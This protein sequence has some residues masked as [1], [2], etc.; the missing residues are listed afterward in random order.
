MKGQKWQKPEEIK[1]LR[2]LG[3]TVKR[4]PLPLFWTGSG[5]ECN[6]DGTELWCEFESD[7]E[8]YEQWI[9]VFVNGALMSRLMLNKGRQQVC[10]Y[11]NMGTRKVNHIKVVKEVQAMPGDPAAYLAICG[12][13]GDGA[14]YPLPEP[15]CRIEFIGDSITSGEGSYGSTVE[16]DW[17]AMWFSAS[18]TFPWFVAERLNAEYRVFSQ[19][20]YGVYCAYD[21]N[22][23]HAMP[24]YYEQVCGVL[25]GERN[26]ALG[27]KERYEFSYWQPDYIVINLGTND[28][29]AFHN[30]EWQDEATGRRNKMEVGPD[31]LPEKE[32]LEKVRHAVTEFLCMVRKYNPEAQILWAYGLMG[33]VVE[34]AITEGIE[35]FRKTSGDTKVH[36]I[37]LD[38]IKGEAVGARS[39]PGELG[40]RAAAESICRVIEGLKSNE[41]E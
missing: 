31:G 14:F 8:L 22:L 35:D 6:Y 19:S 40:H 25:E 13:S 16:Q 10:L 15:A 29:G 18:R 36:Y 28:G 20:G 24:L 1:E 41:K 2:I 17:I 38:E 21:N 30:P 9:A 39:H 33:T 23:D 7:Y 32:C 5:F 34:S 11:R 3:R 26:T 37:R 4:H 12:L 27:A